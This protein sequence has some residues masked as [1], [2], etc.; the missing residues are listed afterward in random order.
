MNKT[1][2]TGRS[3]TKRSIA[4]RAVSFI[5]LISFFLTSV[6]GDLIAGK[7]WAQMSPVALT[8]LRSA[9]IGVISKN[10]F[11]IEDFIIPES[12]GA[13]HDIHNAD[14]GK[15]VIYI[16]DA[17]C[18]YACQKKISGLLSY[19][20]K[21]YGI[22]TVNLEGGK[23]PY[24]F[25]VFADIPEDGIRERVAD[26]FVDKGMVSGAEY[27][28]INNP[29][30][31]EL[32][33]MEDPVLYMK[34]L[35]V[36]RDSLGYSTEVREI[37]KKTEV[38]LE[39]LKNRIFSGRLRELDAK[40]FQYRSKAVGLKE[41]VTYLIGYA[42]DENIALDEG[43]PNVYLLRQTL[44]QEK[45]ID[46]T[47]ANKE[48]DSLID[49]LQKSLSEYE[50]ERLVIKTVQFKKEIIKAED[51]YSYLIRKAYIAGI[52]METL[53]DLRKYIDY[54][55]DYNTVDKKV[56]MKELDNLEK[57]IK[58]LYYENDK[59]REL[60][61]LSRNLIVLKNL[62]DVTMT[63]DEYRYYKEN[64]DAFN[65]VKYRDFLKRESPGFSVGP[66]DTGDI[67]VLDRFRRK[68]DGFYRFS[69]KRDE[70]FMDN[71]RF[72]EV[73][74]NNGGIQ[75]VAVV[76]TG[77]FHSENLL[78]LFKKED[79]SYVS[80]TPDFKNEDEYETPYFRLLSGDNGGFTEKV[81]KLFTSSI[82]IA[83]FLNEIN[84]LA[85]G[86]KSRVIFG[87]HARWRAAAERGKG[88][89][90]RYGERSLAMDRDGLMVSPRDTENF[91]EAFVTEYAERLQLESRPGLLEPVLLREDLVN[92]ARAAFSTYIAG[93]RIKLHKKLSVL[94]AMPL[95]E[96]VEYLRS[97][98]PDTVMRLEKGFGWETLL[99]QHDIIVELDFEVDILH[100][101]GTDTWVIVRG[102]KDP[103]SVNT[104]AAGP[105]YLFDI[106]IHNHPGQDEAVPAWDDVK[107]EFYGNV[108]RSTAMY[109][110][111]RNGMTKY[112][113]K[114]IDLSSIGDNSYRLNDFAADIALNRI[115][116]DIQREIGAPIG[117]D[118]NGNVFL[119]PR[120]ER[121]LPY[122]SGW[123]E[124]L[125]VRFEFT[126][127]EGIS[128]GYFDTGK[129]DIGEAI[130]ASN[131]MTRM[132]ALEL[133]YHLLRH[134]K[135]DNPAFTAILGEFHKDTDEGIQF[136]VLN[137][138]I[139]DL[140]VSPERTRAVRLFTRSEYEAVRQEA[141]R[142]FSYSTTDPREHDGHNFKY[143]THLMKA[144]DLSELRK[145]LEEKPADVLLSGALIV[146]DQNMDHTDIFLGGDHFLRKKGYALLLLKVPEE[147]ILG[148]Y[149]ADGGTG[150]RAAGQWGD[151]EHRSREEIDKYREMRKR[152]PLPAAYDI[153]QAPGYTG[154]NEL[155]CDGLG[156]E[157][158]GVVMGED[159]PGC[160]VFTDF[161][162]EKDLPLIT[163]GDTGKDKPW[164]R[165]SSE[166]AGWR[167]AVRR[168]SQDQ[169]V[170][171]GRWMS[172][173]IDALSAGKYTPAI[174][175]EILSRHPEAR[176]LRSGSWDVP[177]AEGDSLKTHT[178]RALN[179]FEKYFAGNDVPLPLDRGLM[180]VIMAL[181]DIGKPRA[182]MEGDVNEQH[183]RTVEILESIRKDLPFPPDQIDAAISFITGEAVIDRFMRSKGYDESIRTATDEIVRRA[184]ELDMSPEDYLL[185]L[186]A[187]YQSDAGAYS[188][189]AGARGGTD[190]LLGAF[191][192]DPQRE[193]L[194]FTGIKGQSSKEE[195]FSRLEE[196][197]KAAALHIERSE[198]VPFLAYPRI[199]DPR[200]IRAE[201]ARTVRTVVF[202][203]DE[204]LAFFTGTR[205]G[206]VLR[207]GIEE[208]LRLLRDN[209]IRLVMWSFSDRRKVAR[210]F[211][212][213]P[214]MAR[215]FDLVITQENYMTWG[216]RPD[217]VH[218]ELGSAY[219]RDVKGES[220]P[221]K[222]V[223]LLGYDL[224]VDDNVTSTGSPA[225]EFKAYR[226]SAFN[227]GDDGEP[228]GTLAD[229]I[230][231]M[232]GIRESEERE[233][234][235]NYQA[236]RKELADLGLDRNGANVDFIALKLAQITV[237]GGETADT[238]PV[239]RLL[240]EQRIDPGNRDLLI[241]ALVHDIGKAGPVGETIPSIVRAEEE[242]H[243][244]AT[245]EG[246]N[247]VSRIFGLEVPA[248]E[249]AKKGIGK[250]TP[251][252]VF[253][254]SVSDKDLAP[255][256]KD[257]LKTE[258][259]SITNPFT[260][261]HYDVGMDTMADLWDAHSLWSAQIL[262]EAH[263]PENI[264]NMVIQ[265]HRINLYGE[266]PAV[267]YVDRS[268]P[269][270]NWKIY[271][272]LGDD[273]EEPDKAAGW[274]DKLGAR[275]E[276]IKEMTSGGMF[277][278]IA[279]SVDAALRRKGASP[280]S[281]KAY[282]MGVISASLLDDAHKEEFMKL[283]DRFFPDIK[284][285]I[286]E[287]EREPGDKFDLWENEQVLN[288]VSDLTNGMRNFS[289]A[290][291]YDEDITGDKG[292]VEGV[293]VHS[294]GIRFIRK[295][296]NNINTIRE[297][298][299]TRSPVCCPTYF[300]EGDD[301]HVYELDMR[302]AAFGYTTLWDA[303]M[304]QD[305]RFDPGNREMIRAAMIRAFK[306]GDG[307]WFSHNHPHEKNILVNVENGR[308]RDVKFID[309]RL[310]REV[311]RTVFTPGLD[312]IETRKRYFEAVELQ[313][314]DFKGSDMRSARFV[315]S[316]LQDSD[317]SGLNIEGA[318]FSFSDLRG[319]NFGGTFWMDPRGDTDPEGNVWLN[320]CDLRDVN[321][322]GA[323]ICFAHFDG[324]DL[325]GARFNRDS[326][327]TG[328]DFSETLLNHV[329]LNGAGMRDTVLRNAD[330]RGVDLRGVD[331]RGADLR[332][333]MFD[334][335][336]KYDEK[337]L[338]PEQLGS[339]RF[340]SGEENPGITGVDLWGL[341]GLGNRLAS[342]KKAFDSSGVD[343][344]KQVQYL[345]PELQAAK[346]RSV[347]ALYQ[348][349]ERDDRMQVIEKNIRDYAAA[350]KFFDLPEVKDNPWLCP[351]FLKDG[352]VFELNLMPL[353]YISLREYLKHNVL[354]GPVR[355]GIINAVSKSFRY[356]GAWFAHGHLHS[357]N[358][359]LKVSSGGEVEDVKIIDW[360]LLRED[361]T[362]D[363]RLLD[364]PG[365]QLI[366]GASL[367]GYIFN[368]AELENT[369]FESVSLYWSDLE[370][371]GMTNAS[372]MGGS[373]YGAVLDGAAMEGVALENVNLELSS[374][375]SARITGGKIVNCNFASA[376][377]KNTYLEN[378]EFL[379]TS[380]EQAD[381][382]GADVGGA[383]FRHAVMVGADIRDVEIDPAQ[384][385]SPVMKNTR[386]DERYG[387]M[388]ERRGFKVE[389][390][391][392]GSGK[393]CEVTSRQF[394][395]PGP[396]AGDIRGDAGTDINIADIGVNGAPHDLV[397]KIIGRAMGAGYFETKEIMGRNVRVMGG[398][399]TRNLLDLAAHFFTEDELSGISI[400]DVKLL[401]RQHGHAGIER[402]QAYVVGGAHLDVGEEDLDGLI[403]HELIELSLWQVK[404]L[405]LVG[406]ERWS[407][408][409]DLSEEERRYAKNMLRDWIRT[410][411]D[412]ENTAA[413]FHSL[414]NLQSNFV[415]MATMPTRLSNIDH[416]ITEMLEKRRPQGEW[417]VGDV[418][419]GSTPVT[420]FE[421]AHMLGDRG[422]VVGVNITIPSYMMEIHSDER[423]LLKDSPDADG[424]YYVYFDKNGRFMGGHED[425][426]NKLTGYE[427]EYAAEALKRLL[428]PGKA[429]AETDK[430][431]ILLE[432]PMQ[433]YSA[434]NMEVIKGGFDF[435]YH[436]KFDLIRAF[437]V[438]V[439]YRKNEVDQ[440][441]KDLGRNL[442]VGG[443]LIAGSADMLEG[444]EAFVVYEKR[445]Y[446]HEAE[447]RMV[448]VYLGTFAGIK[449][450]PLDKTMEAG[451]PYEE[452]LF[453]KYTALLKHVSDI[454]PPGEN[455]DNFGRM[456]SLVVLLNDLVGIINHEH[457][458]PEE[459]LSKYSEY[460]K[461]NR[462][463]AEEMAEESG[464]KKMI[465]ALE[466]E[467]FS[468]HSSRSGHIL[469]NL[470]PEGDVRFRGG[471]RFSLIAVYHIVEKFREIE[472]KRLSQKRVEGQ[473]DFDAAY[474][475]T[476]AGVEDGTS[477]AGF[478]NSIEPEGLAIGRTAAVISGIAFALSERAG[479][480]Q[481]LRNR[482]VETFVKEQSLLPAVYAA[483]RMIA[484]EKEV[485]PEG[486]GPDIPR[487]PPSG[488]GR[489]LQAAALAS[490]ISVILA[491][492]NY[493]ESAMVL[494]GF[495]ILSYAA[496]SELYKV[497]RAVDFVFSERVKRI[498]IALAAAVIISFSAPAKASV[499][500]LSGMPAGT[501]V[502]PSAIADFTEMPKSF[503]TPDKYEQMLIE[504]FAQEHLD[505][506]MYRSLW[507][508]TGMFEGMADAER[509][510]NILSEFTKTIRLT[511]ADDDISE[512]I[513]SKAGARGYHQVMPG[514]F[515]SIL[516]KWEKW[517]IE[518]RQTGVLKSSFDMSKRN[519]L[520]NM[521]ETPENLRKLIR[522]IDDPET[523]ARLSVGLSALNL[524]TINFRKKIG[525]LKY[526]FGLPVINGHDLN[527]EVIL[528]AWYNAGQKDVERAANKNATSF[529]GFV[530]ALPKS[531]DKK[532][533]IINDAGEYVGRYMRRRLAALL[534]E[535]EL[536]HGQIRVARAETEKTS[537]E[538][539]EEIRAPDEKTEP[540][541][542]SVEAA[543][544]LRDKV[545]GV[546]ARTAT[547][548][549]GG[550]I[551]KVM[552][553]FLL[554]YVL[555][556]M[557]RTLAR[558][559]SIR[560]ITVSEGAGGA[561]S[562]SI[563][564]EP[565]VY[566][567]READDVETMNA[568]F[569][570]ALR[571]YSQ[572]MELWDKNNVEE[573]LVYA[574]AAVHRIE[575]LKKRLR[576]AQYIKLIKLK[577][578][579]AEKE[580]VKTVFDWSAAK[581]EEGLGRYV[582]VRDGTGMAGLA[583]AGKAAARIHR[584][585][586]AI[587]DKLTLFQ[588][589]Q[590]EGMRGVLDGINYTRTMDAEIGLEPAPAG[591][592]RW[593]EHLKKLIPG[594][595]G[596][597]AYNIIRKTE[598]A[599]WYRFVLGPLFEEIIFRGFS[600]AVALYSPVLGLIAYAF[601]GLLFYGLHEDEDR[602]LA[603]IISMFTGV[604]GVLH[605]AGFVNPLLLFY[606]IHVVVNTV[607]DMEKEL[608]L[609]GNKRFR[610]YVKIGKLVSGG[611]IV[612]GAAFGEV[613]SLGIYGLLSFFA[614][615]MT[616]N[617][618][619]VKVVKNLKRP[620]AIRAS[621][622]RYAGSVF[623]GQFISIAGAKVKVDRMFGEED[624]E[625]FKIVFPNGREIQL[626]PDET[627]IGRSPAAHIRVKAKHVGAE[628]FDKIAPFHTSIVVRPGGV[629]DIY[630]LSGHRA[631]RVK[632]WKG[633]AEPG[634][635]IQF[636]RLKTRLEEEDGTL[637]LVSM[638]T[639]K[640][641]PLKEGRNIVGRSSGRSTA[642]ITEDFT[643]DDIIYREISGAH[644]IL[645]VNPGTGVYVYDNDSLNGTDVE[646]GMG[647]GAWKRARMLGRSVLKSGR[648][649][650]LAA[651]MF[652]GER[653]W[654]YNLIPRVVLFMT[655]ATPSHELGHILAG[656]NKGGFWAGLAAMFTGEVKAERA[657]PTRAGILGNLF[658]ASFTA[659]LAAVISTAP[660]AHIDLI[661]YFLAAVT[662]A[663]IVSGL[664][665]YIGLF[666]GTGDLVRKYPEIQIEEP[667][668]DFDPA[669]TYTLTKPVDAIR[670]LFEGDDGGLRVLDIGFGTG[671]NSIAAK[672]I[673]DD[674]ISQVTGIDIR[675]SDVDFANTWMRKYAGNLAREGVFEDPEKLMRVLETKIRSEEEPEPVVN[676]DF[677]NV[678]AASM[679]FATG[680]IQRIMF[681]DSYTFI[682]RHS[683][684]GKSDREKAVEEILRV[685]DKEN[686]LIHGRP[687]G[688][689]NA[690]EVQEFKEHFMGTA[691][692]MG[693]ELTAEDTV[694]GGERN[695][696]LFRVV[697]GSVTSKFPGV[698]GFDE[699]TRSDAV[700]RE[701]LL[702]SAGLLR[703]DELSAVDSTLSKAVDI[704]YEREGR[705]PEKEDVEIRLVDTATVGIPRFYGA[706]SVRDQ[707]FLVGD[708]DGGRI[709]LYT[710]HK[711]LNDYLLKNPVLLADRLFHEYQ[712][713]IEKKSHRQASLS[714]WDYLDEETGIPVY[715]KISSDLAFES[716]EREYLETLAAMPH[717]NDLAG[718]FSS[719]LKK[720][721]QI[722]A[723][724]GEMS[725]DREDV[726]EAVAFEV[727]KEVP[728]TMTWERDADE[729]IRAK[730]SERVDSGMSGIELISMMSMVKQRVETLVVESDRAMMKRKER[731]LERALSRISAS[732]IEEIAGRISATSGETNAERISEIKRNLTDED[733]EKLRAMMA[734][735]TFNPVFPADVFMFASVI[736][737]GKP[738][739]RLSVNR[740]ITDD[741][742]RKIGIRTV[743]T[744]TV[745][746]AGV[747]NVKE[748]RKVLDT[749]RDRLN[750]ELGGE[751]GDDLFVSSNMDDNDVHRF[752]QALAFTN[753]D[754]AGLF[755]GYPPGSVNAYKDRNKS[756]SRIFGFDSFLKKITP[757]DENWYL[758]FGEKLEDTGPFEGF[759]IDYESLDTAVDAVIAG[760]AGYNT[761]LSA[762]GIM[763]PGGEHA[764]AAPVTGPEGGVSG[765]VTP[766]EFHG[767]E[768]YRGVNQE[769]VDL[770]VA[771]I[772]PR[773][774]E[775]FSRSIEDI[776]AEPL[777]FSIYGQDCEI[778]IKI[779][780]SYIPGGLFD[781][782]RDGRVIAVDSSSLLDRFGESAD[783][784]NMIKMIFVHEIPEALEVQLR[785]ALEEKVVFNHNTRHTASMMLE[786]MISYMSS[787]MRSV[788]R[789]FW[790]QRPVAYGY[791]DVYGLGAFSIEA[792]I[793]NIR[794]NMPPGETL[795]A[796]DEAVIRG[797]ARNVIVHHGDQVRR[798]GWPY[799]VHP[800]DAA[801]KLVRVFGVTDPV[802]IQIS[803]MHD[804]LEDRPERCSE[805]LA[806]M[807]AEM[808]EDTLNRIR[809]GIDMLTKKEGRGNEY[810]HDLVDPEKTGIDLDPR[811]KLE[812][813]RN[814][815]LV[816][817][818]DRLSNIGDL[819]SLLLITASRVANADSPE[820]RSAASR[821]YDKAR[822]LALKTLRKTFA[823][824]IPVFVE[825]SKA[826]DFRPGLYDK[827]RFYDEFGRIVTR[828]NSQE[829]AR[830][831]LG[832]LLDTASRIINPVV[833]TAD[834]GIM[835]CREGLDI[836]KEEDMGEK[837]MLNKMSGAMRLTGKGLYPNLFGGEE[838]YDYVIGNIPTNEQG[839]PFEDFVYQSAFSAV[840]GAARRW[841]KNKNLGK[842]NLRDAIGIEDAV[843]A[844]K[845]IAE[846]IPREKEA[847]GIPKARINC[848]MGESVLD[849]LAR[850]E[851]E[852]SGFRELKKRLG[853][854]GAIRAFLA[855]N[856]M[857]EIIKDK[858]PKNDRMIYPMSYG[859]LHNMGLARLNLVYFME[860][861][862]DKVADKG[863][864]EY[865]S[866]RQVVKSY[867]HAIGLVSNNPN[868]F[869]ITE[870][871]LSM[872][873]GRPRA[874]F[875][876]TIFEIALPPITAID[877]NVIK[878]MFMAESEVLRSL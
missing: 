240:L 343:G 796:A 847:A 791:G 497:F 863:N 644:A 821:S 48:R 327:F 227:G 200:F 731:G 704:I 265:H 816:K 354:S 574:H 610:K 147:Y 692:S 251:I 309:W 814:I 767:P 381:L 626:L 730:L 236:I 283:A 850:L 97:A 688:N 432:R 331:L 701:K 876:N 513:R 65:A 174:L 269:P 260:L 637:G 787:E 118:K 411:P 328:S 53:P 10:D 733:M 694:I 246:I 728:R 196:A 406:K 536:K 596:T 168:E 111:S 418:G 101:R 247:F 50:I 193:R 828:F 533:R 600:Y 112:D 160:E 502:V 353:G 599:E 843:D 732:R 799:F 443:L 121:V 827:M 636:A 597:R 231:G 100:V 649:R 87:M 639:G 573:G 602:P 64:E 675:Q 410:N 41:Y 117:Y 356:G 316:Y 299:R 591:L 417:L 560:K 280:A 839:E 748:V 572:G 52:D 334:E 183:A 615:S 860:K 37:I 507:K 722:L 206:Y 749:Y 517:E 658:T 325:R 218:D 555:A 478:V 319:S 472:E 875:R 219:G 650:S 454:V 667:L 805:M 35:R 512:V 73:R 373:L 232:L 834:S 376:D 114:G 690:R 352:R 861:M 582:N 842:V 625:W 468:I 680:S 205:E 642:V 539:A 761:A 737:G 865:E 96:T 365:G 499:S 403:R 429:K 243:R 487:G 370:K 676:V 333:A 689:A 439:H 363:R 288:A 613:T 558:S 61:S 295:K 853:I 257:R 369:R 326:M 323:S 414:A 595:S 433:R 209:G 63:V 772:Q 378:T 58:E 598:R 141:E 244:I 506:E 191:E 424:P 13:V 271:R 483:L 86:E 358:I 296:V 98:P 95:R 303:L 261:R 741:V 638:K 430:G 264:I 746:E 84:D 380:F 802:Y 161:A 548:M 508:E 851:Q 125:N 31:I 455:L 156:T 451:Y 609:S 202:D 90:I 40:Y 527:T 606:I 425:R 79:I 743:R 368:N 585:G 537:G 740:I 807:D 103:A 568:L 628:I 778:S 529:K 145:N 559:V 293:Y 341:G 549:L 155:L 136:V 371:A 489:T 187:L 180:R 350:R 27:Y 131:P 580:T 377:M 281:A 621:E 524:N 14:S 584:F 766:E 765:S 631:T 824:F 734:P 570:D 604:A 234:Q 21:R 127:W 710:T 176:E 643:G 553:A 317:F 528:A 49:L 800:F 362:T 122:F 571:L 666:L 546:F 67:M 795:S 758:G 60:D 249:R 859:R 213:Y 810:L 434:R 792:L 854:D 203:L 272:M 804:L 575:N 462:E 178:L 672:S 562:A 645:F 655:L 763:P 415:S 25:R 554:I 696:V 693:F 151:R 785:S 538:Q 569:D 698:A 33:G 42:M 287:M 255:G 230:M 383:V 201:R 783:I 62:F 355:S 684:Y 608:N 59:Q 567:P 866:Y 797:T 139:R 475:M 241:A 770:L 594:F 34:N 374:M 212:K 17:H 15:S 130:Q 464:R 793:S 720:K 864:K 490:G 211:Q 514:A 699:D 504:G 651:N 345:P 561:A 627:V 68:M 226:I 654:L 515:G 123:L 481:R 330:L 776:A 43:F 681:F 623:P 210:F 277:L 436:E 659:F 224:L 670:P 679:P 441:V 563:S 620:R 18:N 26:Y 302:P 619:A 291:G 94:K 614:A 663:N 877:V 668:P 162:A 262:A 838:C 678:S 466:D 682:R 532:G 284:T 312:G 304:S 782:S 78:G 712:E 671:I 422:R 9:G 348:Y 635:E 739:A 812:F 617:I 306:P 445:K 215:Q 669:W 113:S 634:Q 70:A 347:L 491:G 148:A 379:N 335:H 611:L 208:Q 3:G 618:H 163:V 520:V 149:H 703:G 228:V 768:G 518:I 775:I 420:T 867:A 769:H 181:H 225:G 495:L 647:S 705:S 829:K 601:T 175:I 724:E 818:S 855:D 179:L 396:G 105:M 189:M 856:T 342:I 190:Y 479:D 456:I 449:I 222:D 36:Y 547:G 871:L 137:T 409:A 873:G 715:L 134:E 366:I 709:V 19:L 831:V 825:G 313:G 250:H 788:M 22:D 820:E 486:P 833:D 652:S 725:P 702:A 794:D 550:L 589:G 632:G 318:S 552:P 292:F 457:F 784:V 656:Q 460:Q 20:D 465:T 484:E 738:Y 182:I 798:S 83:S 322:E 259:S 375:I 476:R 444:L 119:D 197:V 195:Q 657:P 384:F 695:G 869:Q 57:R 129:F 135:L 673:Y 496:L 624:D 140:P 516:Q 133:L 470:D 12:L 7:A 786:A 186:T 605:L 275:Y 102:R 753:N 683:E 150:G 106:D 204:T 707:D 577:Y 718:V 691:R 104:G 399:E 44:E 474:E 177:V 91:E 878:E 745:A 165:V 310:V 593:S 450:T 311:P 235:R 607:S 285:T 685:L 492:I 188:T 777:K 817:L 93:E 88:L 461:R 416:L 713:L 566:E 428:D 501:P 519:I 223:A 152:A 115:A 290:Q 307:S 576:G 391:G 372:M 359:M 82:A 171:R 80:I 564:M 407:V 442:K 71:I 811:E 398:E 339:V 254:D 158:V 389:Y 321:F 382:R 660:L 392:D 437:N 170:S 279:D 1:N 726:I 612:A 857:L 274:K 395:M 790:R 849:A 45:E 144:D 30:G 217:A 405:E 154:W 447:P 544:V 220:L 245:D 364:T 565:M 578:E 781:I 747:Y 38:A 92:R 677:V 543:P 419:V 463:I 760:R 540:V 809:A 665:E 641:L 521:F 774:D 808:D 780:K 346:G 759:L 263:V 493:A 404:A 686:G 510:I 840:K 723:G 488:S 581:F 51:F 393:W 535:E 413:R 238:M 534:Y 583:L 700:F 421:L 367:E 46:F 357:G 54:L 823:T 146:R 276:K 300:I 233:I 256:E 523:N 525:K 431:N 138:L 757:H 4:F 314:A 771:L 697:P 184:D 278:L 344:F 754:I 750:S 423:G 216:M 511:E 329:N 640:K 172:A 498:V 526:D 166:S 402:D 862:G 282:V 664:A 458:R 822:A 297:F 338:T 717:E 755:Y 586:A 440:A 435:G 868:V 826:L 473:E 320:R 408:W 646:P 397:N 242:A 764:G 185:A 2:T 164:G 24:D 426:A 485:E 708:M 874:Y 173:L 332:G 74:D 505:T 630:D 207:P 653:A 830:E 633:M 756:Q 286:P 622:G 120:D 494:G 340:V 806:E 706:S 239:M 308:L 253:I 662:A 28:A 229:R 551:F 8:D 729:A 779:G 32:W 590:V 870:S 289:R 773:I 852:D 592:I 452:H 55:Y 167:E 556:G 467:G 89:I 72:S 85:Y 509:Q 587:S 143:I 159:T 81:E 132:R 801:I 153:L 453:D 735:A 199:Y 305:I 841:V 324:S 252:T 6:C 832:D 400:R 837:Y 819:D 108:G 845:E 75:K 446:M 714:M 142:F 674:K 727:F 128:G 835:A 336:T 716:G 258:L 237:F 109:I 99:R 844:V 66:G 267:L 687:S 29:G 469:F 349:D 301:E 124:E 858:N 721:L 11:N 387:G 448:P 315:W 385:I 248:E 386:F 711:F 157:I 719:Y 557:A 116:R 530:E 742:L 545:M 126:P 47:R 192:F 360:S 803:L 813:M 661:S 762:L 477:L 388:F 482:F 69:F 270:E 194:K 542:S 751:T 5:T 268:G 789:E 459:Y 588:K 872:A 736:G 500:D 16:Q 298:L 107:S 337:D 522:N 266:D 629:L 214:D 836:L 603:F 616:V 169:A 401:S 39:G 361:E 221:Q 351:T 273:F 471:P 848:S 394:D 198:R 579:L 56:L 77:G 480:S 531:K 412:A 390:S 744:D 294:S 23:G 76:I 648:V 503:F 427:I 438:M 752:M 846:L 541:L 815:H 110:M